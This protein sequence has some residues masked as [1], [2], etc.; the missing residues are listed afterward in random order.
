MDVYLSGEECHAIEAG[1]EVYFQVY[2]NRHGK[3]QAAKVSAVNRKRS[4]DSMSDSLSV[5]P[6]MSA[7]AAMLPTMPVQGEA[8]WQAAGYYESLQQQ[9]QLAQIAQQQA[10]QQAQQALLQ[11]PEYWQNATFNGS[12]KRLE[13][14]QGYGFIQCDDTFPLFHSDIFLHQNEAAG[15]ELGSEVT[16]HI[17]F[18]AKGQPQA[19]S[20]TATG[21]KVKRARKD[22][23]SRE[24]GDSPDPRP[25]VA[26][27]MTGRVKTY[28]TTAG[29]GFIDCALTRAMF[30]HDVFLH[31][32]YVPEGLDVGSKVSFQ[33]RL[34]K[35]S[36][37]QAD[38]VELLDPDET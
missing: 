28:N 13:H 16:F 23:G 36:Q 12:V 6:H 8:H 18:N 15:L 2:L 32:K 22:E 34:N 17:H 4:Y 9:A 33:V 31:K 26:G 14:E 10:H 5:V 35:L 30:G 27:P 29:Y 20:V 24:S 19:N 25:V 21:G 3:P 38:N 1:Q 7:A 11:N 37:P